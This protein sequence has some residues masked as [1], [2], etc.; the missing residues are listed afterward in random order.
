MKYFRCVII[1][2]F[3]FCCSGCWDQ[4]LMKDVALITAIAYDHHH[5]G[6]LETTLFLP[7]VPNTIIGMG[8]P[9]VQIPST[10]SN[11][12]SEGNTKLDAKVSGV[13][14][15]AKNKV[16]LFGESFAKKDIYSAIDAFYRNPKSDLHASMVVIKG[17]AKNFMKKIKLKDEPFS[18]YMSRIIQSAEENG[19]TKK[20]NVQRVVSN[21]LD[22]GKD[23]LLPYLQLDKTQSRAD[24]KGLAMFHGKRYSGK[25]LSKE[26]A[27]LYLL[28]ANQPVENVQLTKKVN[29]TAR[30]GKNKYVTILVKQSEANLNIM[31]QNNNM[32]VKPHLNLKVNVIE[33]I[34]YDSH[35]SNRILEKKLSSILTK[36][37]KIVFKDLQEAQC[38]G[39]GIGRKTI[40]LH[41]DV[42]KKQNWEKTYQEIKFTPKV[43]VHIINRSN[44]KE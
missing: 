3:L 15:S 33:N 20:Q 13:L 26:Q 14:D 37:S 23:F 30:S 19:L 22:P 28:L 25:F 7:R 36:E 2:F 29:R 9:S 34:P 41:P 42:W 18:D 24:I 12:P 31:F 6:K 44:I 38:D 35:L 8:K 1:T 11:T 39:L 32:Q 40:A 16:L 10:L 27:K 21:I 4:Y 5:T 17:T 43:N